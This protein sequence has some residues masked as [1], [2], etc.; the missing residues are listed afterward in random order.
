MEEENMVQGES[1]S[2][3]YEAEVNTLKKKWTGLLIRLLR[4]F[5]IS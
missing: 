3:E 1:S 4:P 2:Q 5:K